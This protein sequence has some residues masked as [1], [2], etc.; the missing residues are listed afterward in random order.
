MTRGN[1]SGGRPRKIQARAATKRKT[2]H[3]K[4]AK[5]RG[6]YEAKKATRD[7]T[8]DPR[9]TKKDHVRPYRERFKG[10]TRKA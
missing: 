6:G 3:A 1:K 10:S 7:P 8:R 4:E 5:H 2:T 9:S